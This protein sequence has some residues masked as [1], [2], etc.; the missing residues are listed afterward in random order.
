MEVEIGQERATAG[1]QRQNVLKTISE[2]ANGHETTY[3]KMQV[4]M[5]NQLGSCYPNDRTVRFRYSSFGPIYAL[6]AA[7]PFLSGI[8]SY[9]GYHDVLLVA[10]FISGVFALVVMLPQGEDG[11]PRDRLFLTLLISMS[12]SLLLAST[13]MGN[14]HGWDIHEE[15]YLFIQVSKTSTWLPG[16]DILYNSSLSVT[17]LPWIIAQVTGLDGIYIFIVV[18][19]LVFGIV[20]PLLYRIFR[21]ILS[22]EAAFLSVFFLM[23]YPA[24]YEEM[25]QLGRQ[26]VAE[27]M[28]VLLVL[29]FL[30]RGRD[31]RAMRFAQILLTVGLVMAHYSL[32]YVYIFVMTLSYIGLRVSRQPAKTVTAAYLALTYVF[33]LGWNWSVAGGEAL[34]RWIEAISSV[35][36]GLG[37]DFFNPS[38]RPPVVLQALGLSTV[39][40]GIL[41]YLNRLTQYVVLFSVFLGLFILV[42]KT[43]KTP[44]ENRLLTLTIPAFLLLSSAVILPYLGGQLNLSRFYHISMLLAAPCFAYGAVALE[45]FLPRSYFLLRRKLVPARFRRKWFLAATLLF[46][47]F[48]FLSGWVWS[49]SGDTPTS[50]IL[51][52]ARI[53]SYPE[54]LM[55]VNYYNG[56]TV[57][58]DIAAARWLRSY[59]G[60]HGPLCADYTSRY[61]VLNS[62]GEFPRSDPVW[63]GAPRCDLVY[64]STLN[65][66]YGLGAYGSSIWYVNETFPQLMTRNRIFSGGATIY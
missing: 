27:V 32:A 66:L 40:P 52:R 42:R 1:P 58:Q 2:G 26:E 18:W 63:P 11:R 62:Y 12:L 61:L 39:T 57:D 37:N 31:Q 14:L 10:F 25:T 43:Q 53:R 59:D 24:S 21:R 30:Y 7:L 44:T 34:G 6:A 60:D 23:S 5:K 51:D 17:I 38:S 46:L 47:Y 15:Y 33:A 3:A 65:T 19:P 16:S 20:P 8:A 45:S 50:L 64:L 56:V 28:F 35:W 41:H 13:L 48:I 9:F 49:V 54:L 55:R 29:M 4:T 22:P 36:T